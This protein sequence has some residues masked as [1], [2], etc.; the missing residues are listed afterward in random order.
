M[1][2]RLR[3]LSPPQERHLSPW[4][5]AG[6]VV[7]VSSIVSAQAQGATATE[8]SRVVNHPVNTAIALGA[9][10]GGRSVYMGQALTPIAGGTA[11][12]LDHNW[13]RPRGMTAIQ[14]LYADAAM[15]G[16]MGLERRTTGWNSRSRY[17]GVASPGVSSEA[18]S[19]SMV[20][21]RTPD[22]TRATDTR[23]AE[24]EIRRPT[25]IL[26]QSG[27]AARREAYLDA[28][29]ALFRQEKYREAAE[30]FGL[31]RMIVTGDLKDRPQLL[32]QQAE[33]KVAFIYAAVAAGRYSEAAN[34][35]TWLLTPVDNT[36]QL[37]QADAA[38]GH[39]PDPLFLTNVKNIREKYADGRAFSGHLAALERYVQS[40]QRQAAAA[41]SQSINQELVELYALKAFMQWSDVDNRESRINA[42]F[43]AN[44]LPPPWRGLSQA[45]ATAE[46][47]STDK[48]GGSATGW[49]PARVRLPWEEDS[50]KSTQ[51]PRS[52][53]TGD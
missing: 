7:L 47:A 31:A 3:R 51:P 26:G 16:P 32:K 40:G 21:V 36:M 50:D 42:R 1:R 33:S 2:N 14:R 22:R 17:G 35:L 45:M 23:P 28:G 20:G 46:A 8:R 48:S 18:G 38:T 12:G 53:Q 25:E 27:M 6:C 34:E 4:L 52:A 29:W 9:Q 19:A 11:S 41:A 43:T 10:G 24:F 49:Q 5:A 39:L 37:R 15:K 13:Y 30:N 44:Q